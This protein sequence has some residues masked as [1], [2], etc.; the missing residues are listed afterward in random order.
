MYQRY[1]NREVG[2]IRTMALHI[3]PSGA[4]CKADWPGQ[5]GNRVK[6]WARPDVA[7]PDVAVIASAAK[8]SPGGC[9]PLRGLP[10]RFA[11]RN[12]SEPGDRPPFVRSPDCPVVGGI[13]APSWS[14]AATCSR[15]HF[16]MCPPR[17]SLRVDRRRL[18]ARFHSPTLCSRARASRRGNSG[19]NR[20]A[21]VSYNSRSSNPK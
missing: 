14:N 7:V 20:T 6:L 10:R 12:D 15:A 11:P 1:Q 8:Q 18:G 3:A 17:Q 19:F 4:E 16:R 9:A 13:I 21:I 5:Q 2:V